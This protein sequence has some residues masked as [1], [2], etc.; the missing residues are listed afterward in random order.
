MN[1]VEKWCPK[2]LQLLAQ[3]L[4]PDPAQRHQCGGR[5][6]LDDRG[7]LAA[8]SCVLRTGCACSALA[9]PLGVST[10]TAHRR[11]TE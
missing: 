9:A 6:R 3:P 2:L 7:V 10:P 5:R 8:I 4:L 11:F 1:D